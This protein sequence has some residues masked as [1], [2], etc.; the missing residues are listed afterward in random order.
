MKQSSLYIAL[1]ALSL[2][3]AFCSDQTPTPANVLIDGE[4]R[5]PQIEA[6]LPDNDAAKNLLDLLK[7]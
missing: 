5:R 1:T 7:K 4:D 6:P 2:M 3:L